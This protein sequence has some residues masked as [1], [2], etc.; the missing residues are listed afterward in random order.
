MDSSL[1]TPG[2]HTFQGD[3]MQSS[4]SQYSPPYDTTLQQSADEIAQQPQL[5][6][7]TEDT[8]HSGITLPSQ[9]P[10][11]QRMPQ[12]QYYIVFSVTGIE[13]SNVKN[14]IVR[15]DAKV[16]LPFNFIALHFIGA[17]FWG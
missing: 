8:I 11:R 15:F 4:S 13:R 16:T 5:F 14:P 2:Q 1:E 3:S 10:Q 12:S 9:A 17:N 7:T 6:S